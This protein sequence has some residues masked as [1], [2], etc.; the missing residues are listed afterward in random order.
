MGATIMARV[1]PNSLKMTALKGHMRISAQV[2]CIHKRK[3][4]RGTAGAMFDFSAVLGASCRKFFCPL[5]MI[6]RDVIPLSFLSCRS[7]SL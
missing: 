6:L 4:Y 1:K 5:D 2:N 3:A 7:V